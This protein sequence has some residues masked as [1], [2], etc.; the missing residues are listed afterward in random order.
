MQK[1]MFRGV[2]VE[3]SKITKPDLPEKKKK[4]ILKREK[5]FPRVGKKQT[6]ISTLYI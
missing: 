2:T 4:Q 3:N 5:R 1:S 6:W